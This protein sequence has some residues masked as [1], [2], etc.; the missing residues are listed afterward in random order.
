MKQILP[1]L[2]LAIATLPIAAHAQYQ[3]TYI[4]TGSDGGKSIQDKPCTKAETT[5]RIATPTDLPASPIYTGPAATN[6]RKPRQTTKAKTKRVRNGR[7]WTNG[8]AATCRSIQH[9]KDTLQAMGRSGLSS[10]QRNRV[11]RD[12]RQVEDDLKAKCRNIV[13]Q[14]Y[15]TRGHDSPRP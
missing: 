6:S 7:S 13:P 8:Q 12:L 15:W 14:R 2:L 4:C 9:R 3:T 1:T 11:R 10:G 5:K